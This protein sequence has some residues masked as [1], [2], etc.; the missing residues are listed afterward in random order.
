MKRICTFLLN[1][2]ILLWGLAVLTS[3]N[4]YA[5][6]GFRLTGKVVDVATGEGL[7][8][9]LVKVVN[10]EGFWTLTDAKGGFSFLLPPGAF[11]LEVSYIGYKTE[12]QN[13]LLNADKDLLFCLTPLSY[14]LQDITVFAESPAQRLR[15]AEMSIERVDA[16][17]VQRVPALFGETDLLK[18]VQMLPGV[19]SASEGSS[20]FIVR[21]GSPDQN[22]IL[23]DNAPL[24]NVSHMLGFF[25]IFNTDAVKTMT[26]YKGDMPARYG[27]RLSSLLD[28]IPA[29]G[30]TR[31]SMNGGLGLISSK[32][33]LSGRIGSDNFTYLVAGRRTYADVFLP[34]AKNEIIKNTVLHFYD[35]NGRVRW[36][37]NNKNTINLS[38]YNGMDKFKMSDM[39][40]QFGNLA[41]TL[42]WNR[43]FSD[44][45]YLK[46][47]TTYTQYNYDFR[48]KTHEMSMEWVSRVQDLGLRL[49]FSFIPAPEHVIEFGYTSNF[50][51]FQP[52]KVL[53]KSELDKGPSIEQDITLSHRQGY[54][55]VLYFSNEH[56]FPNL[57]LEVR[58][59]L[60]L[61]RFDNVGPTTLYRVDDNYNLIHEEGEVIPQGVFYHHTY[62]WE[63]RAGISFLALPNLS[64][65][66]SYSRTSQYVHLLSFSSAGSPLEIWIPS[67]PSIAPQTSHQV[68][69]GVFATFFDSRYEVSAEAFYKNLDN[70]LDFKEHPNLLLYDKIETELRFGKGKGYG[71][72]FLIKKNEGKYN[73]WVS[74]TWSRSFRTIPGVNEGKTYRAPTDRP[75]NINVVL[76][77]DITK[78][79]QVSVNWIYATGQ[80][81]T[82]P[83][84]RYWFFNELVPVYTERNAYR[85]PDYHRM[86]AAVT[87]RLDKPGKR[88][89][90]AIHVSVYNLYGR[91]NSWAVNYRMRPT[92][93]QYL[94]MTYLFSVVPSVSWNF[95]F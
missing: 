43:F 38:L 70:V 21:G 46:A 45:F 85:M 73:G 74:Y 77:Y 66:A 5:R 69:A 47:F 81:L 52:G 82:L 71:L 42:N 13:T 11:R 64:V 22:L 53:G 35:L 34:L 18:V 2:V 20:G 23:F 12:Q 44:S 76:F 75:H 3:A 48:G 87:F 49:D 9:A 27:G 16:E 83:E 31:F 4:I 39:G 65:K 68:S 88:L 24:Y 19:Q 10:G 8:G 79:L 90:H 60:R 50:Q 61:T 67:G 28:V 63:P 6:D 91:K 78:R 92:G 25:S 93:E 36:R 59:G 32:L 94:E 62:G 30:Q 95:S 7:Q 37:I 54:V 84:G 51:W 17:V 57:R 29:D 14:H 89:K 41:A 33:A 1:S 56:K 80:P 40:L 86:D 15:K 55:N 72:E 58:Y 26:L